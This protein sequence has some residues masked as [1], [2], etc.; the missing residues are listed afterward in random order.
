MPGL[1][2]FSIIES[3]IVSVSTSITGRAMSEPWAM[4]TAHANYVQGKISHQGD[5]YE[6][7]IKSIMRMVCKDELPRSI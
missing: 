7:L 1:I 3:V 4:T 6:I 2:V 5:D